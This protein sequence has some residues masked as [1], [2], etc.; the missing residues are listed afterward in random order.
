M[1]GYD[2]CILFALTYL[3]FLKMAMY[4]FLLSKTLSHSE[5]TFP[6]EFELFRKMLLHDVKKIAGLLF[7]IKSS[8]QTQRSNEFL[9]SEEASGEKEEKKKK[10][11][12][13]YLF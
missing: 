11:S 1:N 5:K 4:F 6:V 7:S 3:V 12:E 2:P 8:K 9:G 10:K 13:S